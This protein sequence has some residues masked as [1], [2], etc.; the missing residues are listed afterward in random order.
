MAIEWT[1]DKLTGE[2]IKQTRRNTKAFNRVA[3]ALEQI[4]DQN[5]LHFNQDE[6]RMGVI[7]DLVESNKKVV[8]INTKFY[9]IF[10][11]VFVSVFILL[12]LAIIVLAGAE[13]AIELFPS[14]FS[15]LI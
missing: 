4:N 13:R 10:S 12:I 1:K 8:E 14:V 5:K 3:N 11:V 2:F 7:H 15:G 6:E 9:R